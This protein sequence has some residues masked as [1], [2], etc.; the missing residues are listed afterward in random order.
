MNKHLLCLTVDTDPDGLSGKVTDRRTL[1]WLGLEALTTLPV[2]M[3]ARQQLSSIPITWFI[4]ADGQ[5]ESIL[6]TP[7]YLLE[8]FDRFWRDVSPAGHELAWHPHLYRQARSEDEALIISDPSEAKEELERLWDKLQGILRA[9]SF[10]N[11]EGWHTPQT[12]SAIE[13]LGFRCDSTAIPNRKGGND[14]PMNWTGAPNRPYFP[15]PHDLCA[16]GTER[17]LLEVPMNTWMVQAPYDSAPKLRYMNPAVHPQLFASA[18]RNWERKRKFS[19]TEPY[20]WVMI[21]HP[22][23]VFP[24]QQNDQLYAR[25]RSA[26]LT[27][28]VAFQ[29]SLQRANVEVEWVT[30][31]EAAEVWRRSRLKQIA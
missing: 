15:V 31:A 16:A 22:D 25:S 6:G 7:S 20:V 13:R 2:E 23:E 28:L 27:N 10:R 8:K 29:E 17:L 30:I 14:H 21:F 24:A 4:R 12:Y 1:D 11:G 19:S 18:L 9:T 26:L 5:L 3:Q